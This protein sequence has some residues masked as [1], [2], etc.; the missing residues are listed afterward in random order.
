MKKFYA[1]GRFV[2][3]YGALYVSYECNTKELAKDLADVLSEGKKVH[4]EKVQGGTLGEVV[5]SFKI[6]EENDMKTKERMLA[7][8][9][10]LEAESIDDVDQIDD[11][12]HLFGYGRA[13]YRVLTDDEAQEAATDSIRESLWAFNPSFLA[14]QT[15]LPMSVFEALA[16]AYETSNRAIL[17]IVEE[18]CGL[19]DLVEEAISHDGRG[20]FLASY[21]HNEDEIKVNG[22]YYYIYREN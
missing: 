5:T 13:E 19:E 7:L 8:V 16:N 18:S 6:K 10:V 21:D 3:K 2:K 20:H 17:Q 4:V 15:N 11:E 1:D 12:G 14:N 9:C 22:T